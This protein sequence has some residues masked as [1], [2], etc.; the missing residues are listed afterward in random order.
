MGPYPQTEC[1]QARESASARL[2]GELAEL[3]ELRLEAH[4]RDC[5][6]CRA[7]ADGLGGLTAQLRLTPLEHPGTAIAFPQRRRSPGLRIAAAAAAAVAVAS[8]ASFA[9]GRAL[10][11]EAHGHTTTITATATD[12]LGLRTDSMNQHVLAMLRNPAPQDVPPLAR[13]ILL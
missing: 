7:F 9:L 6:D 2:D 10:G 8:G 5:P 12:V 13:I 4:L 3:D 1:S 11:T